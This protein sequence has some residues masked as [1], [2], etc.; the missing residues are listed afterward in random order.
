MAFNHKYLPSFQ[1]TLEFSRLKDDKIK[2]QEKNLSPSSSLLHFSHPPQ[3]LSNR[4]N[5]QRK[6]NISISINDKI[7][8][9]EPQPL[10]SMGIIRSKF[11]SNP[12]SV[13]Q[14]NHLPKLMKP[15]CLFLT[16]S[17]HRKKRAQNP[18]Q[19]TSNLMSQDSNQI[20]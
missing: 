16:V 20:L 1:E 12:S 8:K 14:A 5:T 6:I 3:N 4:N 2:N 15:N 13:A 11:H 17:V 9:F 19:E 18:I 7:T 10:H